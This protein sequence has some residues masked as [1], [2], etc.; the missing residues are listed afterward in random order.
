MGRGMPRKLLRFAIATPLAGEEEFAGSARAYF[1]H[2]IE[3]ARSSGWSSGASQSFASQNDRA[4]K[5]R[6]PD[7]TSRPQFVH[8]HQQADSSVGTSFGNGVGI[9]AKTDAIDAHLLAR[10]GEKAEPASRSRG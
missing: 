4:E 8:G 3:Q 5:E 2:S 1:S 9:L 10:L 6:L 7:G